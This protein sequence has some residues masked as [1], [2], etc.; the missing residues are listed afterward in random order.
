MVEEGIIM[1]MVINGVI[2]FHF[3]I[4]SQEENRNAGFRDRN[5]SVGEQHIKLSCNP[6]GYKTKLTLETTQLESDIPRV[7]RVMRTKT[8]R[9]RVG[10]ENE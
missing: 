8:A 5:K 1:H 10:L 7:P 6:D 3:N 2:Q 9:I 4:N